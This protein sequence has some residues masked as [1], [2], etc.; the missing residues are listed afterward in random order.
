MTVA[1]EEKEP[2]LAKS[3]DRPQRRKGFAAP[4]RL[5]AAALLISLAVWQWRVIMRWRPC[6]HYHHP[7][8]LTYEGES[9]KWESCGELNDHA[10]ECSSIDVPMDQFNATNSGNKTFSIPLIRMR[11]KNATQNILLNPGGPGGSG[12]NLVYRR[13]E[14]L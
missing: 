8:Y 1:T 11:G 2:M 3:L 12:V 10:L 6:K 14:Q 7:R 4:A 9:I 13:G 5:L